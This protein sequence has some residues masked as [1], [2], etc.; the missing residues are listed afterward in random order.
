VVGR[1]SASSTPLKGRLTSHSGQ[2]FANRRVYASGSG[3]HPTDSEGR[4]EIS[5]ESND[6]QRLGLSDVVVRAV[7]PHRHYGLRAAETRRGRAT[8]VTG[9]V[10]HRTRWHRRRVRQPTRRHP[11]RGDGTGEEDRSKPRRRVPTASRADKRVS[12]LRIPESGSTL[13]IS[14]RSPGCT[15]SR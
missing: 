3:Y 13:S 7:G 11:C 9:R 15:D 6:R 14:T 2:P 8:R 5:V 4:F 1:A 12:Q 10:P